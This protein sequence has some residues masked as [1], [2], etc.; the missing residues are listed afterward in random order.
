MP[1]VLLPANIHY[2][3]EIFSA[4]IIVHIVLSAYKAVLLIEASGSVVIL[5]HPQEYLSKTEELQLFNA[6]L[7]KL[8]TNTPA[9]ILRQQINSHYLAAAAEI[10]P[11]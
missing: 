3:A 6:S 4:D 7:H 2:L 10:L 1:S 8:R 9:N 11:P 5:Q